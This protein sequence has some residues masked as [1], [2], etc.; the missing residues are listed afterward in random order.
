MLSRDADPRETTSVD[1]RVKEEVLSAEK[2]L[3]KAS[4]DER[5]E[6]ERLIVEA[7]LMASTQ[8]GFGRQYTFDFRINLITGKKEFVSLHVIEA[9]AWDVYDDKIYVGKE[10]ETL[11]E[12]ICKSLEK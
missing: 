4:A 8:F 9:D 10:A 1:A 12:E 6:G 2:S 3:W 5:A 11:F 7:E